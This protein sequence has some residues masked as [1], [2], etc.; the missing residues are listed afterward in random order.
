MSLRRS[1]NKKSV[2]FEIMKEINRG[3]YHGKFKKCGVQQY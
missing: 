2:V 1:I 3:K